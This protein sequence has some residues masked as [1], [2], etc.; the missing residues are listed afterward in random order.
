LATQVFHKPN[1]IFI[2]HNKNATTN[3]HRTLGTWWSKDGPQQKGLLGLPD[4]E[5]NADMPASEYR[6]RYPKHFIF[7]IVRNPYD[8]VLSLFTYRHRHNPETYPTF[9]GLVKDQKRHMILP[10]QVSIINKN[11][12]CDF[13]ARF[14]NLDMDMKKVGKIIGIK[15]S[16]PYSKTH[17]NRTSHGHYSEYYTEDMKDIVT[18]LYREDLKRFNY[19]Y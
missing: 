8:R 2:G 4:P 12:A 19:E 13:I 16:W 6:K 11:E 5:I 3:V 9:E 7:T 15:W 1:V 17:S 10:T 18:D 14:E